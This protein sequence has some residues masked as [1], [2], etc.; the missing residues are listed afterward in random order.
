M[1]IFYTI[2]LTIAIIFLILILTIVGITL[3]STNNN[4]SFPPT[5]NTCPDYWTVSTCIL[6]PRNMGTITKNSDNTY[7]F[8]S[9]T[10][11]VVD[12]STGKINF[13]D[14]TWASSY[15]RTNQCAL[16]QWTNNN[17]ISWDGVSNFNGC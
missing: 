17:K 10:K 16:Y 13:T 3:N 15:M 12:S 6:D 5:K 1:D 4:Q 14:S 9:S 7:K 8:P 2:V 11:G